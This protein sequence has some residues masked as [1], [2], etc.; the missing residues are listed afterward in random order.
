MN[1][2]QA[3]RAAAKRIEDLE[4]TLKRAMSDIKRY[5]ECIDGMITGQSPCEWCDD[6]ME[7]QREAHTTGKG[8]ELWMLGYEEDT[9]DEKN[10]LT[11]D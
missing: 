9:D 8:C 11:A 3:A 6:K 5:N 4:I 2:R 10:R 7:C 1:G